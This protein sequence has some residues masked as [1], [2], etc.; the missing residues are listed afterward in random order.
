M[1]SFAKNTSGDGLAKFLYR[2]VGRGAIMGHLARSPDKLILG[3]TG[4]NGADTPLF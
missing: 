1:C 3:R 2:F 4:C